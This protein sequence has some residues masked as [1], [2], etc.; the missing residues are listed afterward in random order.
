MHH[1]SAWLLFSAVTSG[2]LPSFGTDPLEQVFPVEAQGDIH[3]RAD[4]ARFL[5]DGRPVLEFALSI[6]RDA[7][8]FDGDSSRVYV[9]L[10]QLNRK[11]KARGQFGR[12]MSLGSPAGQGARPGSSPG[13]ASQPDSGS[14]GTDA[15]RSAKPAAARGPEAPQE[16]WM[17]LTAPLLPDAAGARV[18]LED[19]NRLKPGLLD[20]VQGR[21]R[22]GEA[23]AR[24]VA[25]ERKPAAP[26]WASDLLFVR[27]AAA[28]PG[29][30]PPETGLR[31]VRARLEPNPS[32]YYGLYQPVLTVYWEH[33]PGPEGAE[34]PAAL[35]AE[36]RLRSLADSTEVHATSESLAVSGGAGWTLKRFDVSNLPGGSYRCEVLVR[37]AGRPDRGPLAR[38]QGDFEVV[39]ER[40]SWEIDDSQLLGLGRVLLPA[41]EYEKFSTL[42]RGGMETYLRRLW[43]RI[44]PAEP[45]QPSAGERK[46]YER[47]RYASQNFRGQRA[48]YLSDRGRTYVRYGPP[49]EI[50]RQLNPQDEELLWITLPQEIVDD[51]VDD[52]DAARRLSRRRTPQD[53]SAYEIWDYTVHGDPL[54][55]EY[56]H[57]G[58]PSKM[59]FIFV[60]ESGTGDYT[61]VYT[62]EPSALN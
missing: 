47:V 40:A 48:G 58:Q 29:T 41:D 46:F 21:K 38:I 57:P 20:Q 51:G 49:D 13:D 35:R 23:A 22:A 32:R 34:A 26:V 19:R 3:F 36:Y 24:L 61:L 1:L 2:L 7:L 60:D 37:D 42:E 30:S 10:E 18:R 4:A 62:N 53:N 33:Y 15:G 25:D 44:G 12:E 59:K 31:S 55:P 9:V 5:E 43:N 6:P 27:G 50:R 11:G 28:N 54:L 8:A 56:I 52:Q 17:R 16:L 14:A 39:W 45:G